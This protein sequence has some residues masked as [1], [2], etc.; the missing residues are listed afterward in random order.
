[1][2]VD[3]SYNGNNIQG[4]VND[5]RNDHLGIPDDTRSQIRGL[6]TDSFLNNGQLVVETNEHGFMNFQIT[7]PNTDLP[8]ENRRQNIGNRIFQF[9]N[10]FFN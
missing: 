10:R 2:T 8:V 1:M 9:M 4:D 3:V 7:A 5:H 6:V